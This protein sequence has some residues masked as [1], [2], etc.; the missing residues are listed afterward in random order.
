[1]ESRMSKCV[2]EM[3]Q[4]IR[5]DQEF[6]TDTAQLKASMYSDHKRSDYNVTGVIGNRSGYA[7]YVHQGTGVYASDGKGRKTPWTVSAYY[8]GKY[9]TW[10]TV[11]M[12]PQPFITRLTL[13]EF[14]LQEIARML[15]EG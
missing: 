11:G 6:P 15:G 1:M 14:G 8:K 5:D 2:T 13:S 3:E 12:K 9:R 10:R 4:R 7:F